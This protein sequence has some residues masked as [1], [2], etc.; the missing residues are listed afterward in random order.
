MENRLENPTSLFWSIR[1]LNRSIRGI[2]IK[3]QSTKAWANKNKVN[4]LSKLFEFRRLVELKLPKYSLGLTS[5]R[6]I[7]NYQSITIMCAGLGPYEA[8]VVENLRRYMA[9]T[10]PEGPA[11]PTDFSWDKQKLTVLFR[12]TEDAEY[13]FESKVQKVIDKKDHPFLHIG[14]SDT[15]TRKQKRKSIRKQLNIPATLFLLKRLSK[16]SDGEESTPGLRCQMRDVS[17]DGAAVLI[18]G[19]GTLKASIKLQFYLGS[20]LIRMSGIVRGLSFNQKTQPVDPQ[21]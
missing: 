19:K 12:R 5:S 17:S 15:L 2:L 21:H 14:H 3:F 11:L 10:Y 7:A 18:G 13:I 9:I 1:Q 6:S 16:A 4:F 20:S 8:K